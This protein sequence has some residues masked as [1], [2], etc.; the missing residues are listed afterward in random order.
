MIKVQILTR[1]TYCDGE[2]YLPQGEAIS[3][4]GES[5]QRYAPCP[6]CQGT[7]NITRWISLQEFADLLEKADLLGSF[8]PD[9]D[10]LSH[11]QP[12]SQ[13]QDSRE[14]AGI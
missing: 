2:A 6:R 7:G 8:L 1:C 3:Y 4:T 11:K 13:F 9:Y 5:Y 10:E 14:S 12:T